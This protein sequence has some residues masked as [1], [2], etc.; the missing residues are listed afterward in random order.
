M[1]NSYKSNDGSVE[2]SVRQKGYNKT[3]WTLF[4]NGQYKKTKI[5][6]NNN[7][8]IVQNFGFEAC[9]FN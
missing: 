6:P 2:I 3:A 4:V 7:T 9:D 5:L 8:A 1:K